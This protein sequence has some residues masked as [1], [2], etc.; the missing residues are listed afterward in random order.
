[1]SKTRKTRHSHNKQ[2]GTR[3]KTAR[4]TTQKT[5][6]KTEKCSPKTDNDDLAFTCYSKDSLHKL[7]N[8]WN[9]RHPDV[10]IHSNDSREIWYKLRAYMGKSCYKESCWIK[11]QCIKNALPQDFFLDNFAPKQP[12]EWKKKPNT[13]LTSVDINKVMNQYEKTYPSFIF[14]GPSPIDYDTHKLHNECV[15][16]EICKFSILDYKSKGKNQIGF[17]FN[18]DPHYKDG[19]HWVA[20]FINMKKKTIYYFDSY[21]DN[22]PKQ[23]MKLVMKVKKQARRLGEKYEFVQSHRRHQYLTTEC[24][25]YSLYFVL[26]MLK[27]RPIEIFNKRITDKYMRKLRN[28]YFNKR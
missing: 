17:I 13:W 9:A 23:L 5:K 19:S 15:W 18:L 20:M 16:E 26:Q 12:V 6:F 11:H 28:I 8:I 22:I 2:R 1:M 10:M 27:G 14:L 4:K 7:K 24:G 3:N 21:G 25:M